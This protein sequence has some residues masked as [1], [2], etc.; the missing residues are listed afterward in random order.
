M[1]V[2]S[3][4]E[5]QELLTKEYARFT[6]LIQYQELSCLDEDGDEEDD[7]C[8][9]EECDEEGCCDDEE[10]DE[11][12]TCS[13]EESEGADFDPYEFALLFSTLRISSYIQNVIIQG[14]QKASQKQTFDE[15]DFAESMQWIMKAGFLK[16]E[17]E[18]NEL[19]ILFAFFDETVQP[20]PSEDLLCY[21]QDTDRLPSLPLDQIVTAVEHGMN[22]V[23]RIVKTK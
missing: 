3:L 5:L 21:T 19:A 2:L 9:D 6:V 4:T 8:G 7:C 18:L 10:C 14:Y 23:R 11:E 13:E 1:K 22:V 15:N 17:D 12:E 20:Y 16:K